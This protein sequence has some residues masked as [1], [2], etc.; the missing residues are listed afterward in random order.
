[1]QDGRR[2]TKAEPEGRGSPAEPVD[3]WA[4]A[5]RRELGAMVEPAGQ[6]AEAESG[7]RRLEPES[8]ETST[9]ATLEDGSP[10]KLAPHRWW[11]E[12]EQRGYQTTAVEEAEV[13]GMVGIFEERALE[14]AL[15]ARA[16]ECTFEERVLEDREPP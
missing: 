7:P 5:E 15:E 16:L 12:G 9:T 3:R 10:A 13:G 14:G 8:R 4:T 2:Q 1:M 11:A 6:R